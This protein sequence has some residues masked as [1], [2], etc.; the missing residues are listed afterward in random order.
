[1]VP[2]VLEMAELLFVVAGVVG[3]VSTAHSLF[4]QPSRDG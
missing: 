4:G 1:M 3:L 2:W